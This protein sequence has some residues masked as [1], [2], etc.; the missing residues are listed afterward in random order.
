MTMTELLYMQDF[1]VESCEAS[2]LSVSQ[3]EDGRTD[4]M[5]DQTC[6]Y[7]RGGGQDWDNGTISKDGAAFSVNEVRLDEE[8]NVHHF[9]TVTSGSFAAGDHVNCQVDHERR[10]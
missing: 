3:T 7:A 10:M 2:V 6:F 9:G 5:L 8:G 4:I 1:D